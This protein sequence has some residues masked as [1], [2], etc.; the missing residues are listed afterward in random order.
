MK[1][2][3]A[4]VKQQLYELI[5]LVLYLLNST[6]IELWAAD[7]QPKPNCILDNSFLNIRLQVVV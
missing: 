2:K 3:K 1:E 7:W 6:N 4:L 5:K